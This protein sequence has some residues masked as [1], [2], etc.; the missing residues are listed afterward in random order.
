MT[1]RNTTHSVN[2]DGSNVQFDLV[3]P[4]QFL[5][6][7]FPESLQE[8]FIYQPGFSE[9]LSNASATLEVPLENFQEVFQVRLNTTNTEFRNYEYFVD[10]TKW[11]F[12]SISQSEVPFSQALVDAY[13]GSLNRGPMNPSHN[14]Q[15][16][17]RDMARHVFK[18]I[19]NVER[20][21]NLQQFQN[22]IIKMIEDM[23]GLF[24]EKIL[25]TL[26]SFS[27]LG[28]R[29][30]EDTSM[31]P[32]KIL[33]GTTTFEDNLVGVDEVEQN[34]DDVTESVFLQKVNQEIQSHNHTISQY[35]YYVDSSYGTTDASM[36]YFGPLF[37]D[38]DN[39]LTTAYALQ[40]FV[41]FE[42]E[43]VDGFALQQVTFHDYPNIVFYTMAGMKYDM[44]TYQEY[45]SLSELE[46]NMQG[47][48]ALNLWKGNFVDQVNITVAYP[49][50]DGDKLSL[51]LEYVPDSLNF[52]IFNETFSNFGN[53]SISNR[54]YQ[55][56]LK[57]KQTKIVQTTVLSFQ[58]VLLS[59][60]Q[61]DKYEVKT[62]V[63]IVRIRIE[64]EIKIYHKNVDSLTST[65]ES[66]IGELKNTTSLP[67]IL[68]AIQNWQYWYK[69]WYLIGNPINERQVVETNITS[70]K[71]ELTNIGQT[72]HIIDF[73]L[74]HIS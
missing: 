64:L 37:L 65:E 33:V 58:S 32:L 71:T 25:Q 73:L 8:H 17:K 34:V 54:T 46:T 57:M 11:N 35:A 2:F 14:N 72:S 30:F 26:K 48:M 59:I 15:L 42:E 41:N 55:F 39:V 49:F 43:T 28:F 23:D 4:P 40:R 29:D 27:D 9:T 6:F 47:I 5:S 20:L 1:S 52:Q 50:Q 13:D 74:D 16:V 63:D 60:L 69:N 68:I 38:A 56:F 70:A 19:P 12:N 66:I 61:N 45:D 67:Y 51:L 36:K 24:H 44:G 10:Y 31:N 3:F 7:A 21:N 22:N 18:A 62:I 53:N